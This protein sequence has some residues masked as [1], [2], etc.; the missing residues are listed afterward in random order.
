MGNLYAEGFCL[1]EEISGR[2]KAGL[3]RSKDTLERIKCQEGVKCNRRLPGETVPVYLRVHTF[4]GAEARL[5]VGCSA[6]PGPLR[7]VSRTVY[8]LPGSRSLPEGGKE[9]RD[10]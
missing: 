3:R 5:S 8:L 1:G 9:E 4:S 2:S 6:P 7:V 10:I